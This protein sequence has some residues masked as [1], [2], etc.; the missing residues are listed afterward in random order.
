V[1]EMMGEILAE[2]TGMLDLARHLGF[3]LRHAADPRIIE[4]R[5]SLPPPAPDS[6]MTAVSGTDQRPRNTG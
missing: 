6:G 3:R 4:A 5:F 1:C 2:N